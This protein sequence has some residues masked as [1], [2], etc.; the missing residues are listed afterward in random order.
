VGEGGQEPADAL[1]AR[2]ASA[3][4]IAAL[5]DPATAE[6][7]LAVLGDVASLTE[8]ERVERL[9]AVSSR[10]GPEGF[11]V[12]RL[13][14]HVLALFY[15]LADGEG[16]NPSWE[17][18]GYP[19][20]I[21]PPPTQE[22]APKTIPLT[23]PRGRDA[24]LE[25]DVCVVGSGGG[26]S[27]IAA[28]LQA[29]GRSVLVVEQGGYRN[30][31]DFRQL[32]LAGAGELY[33]GGGLV[34]SETGSLGLLAGATLGGGTVVNSL[35]CLRTPDG[36]R[37]DW[38]GRGLEGLDGPE[39]DAC[40]D[41][42]WARL[43]V[44][45]EGTIPNPSNRRMVEA[46]ERRGLSWELLPRNAAPHDPAFCGYCNAGCQQGE[47]NSTLQTY[48]QDAADAGA[49]FV[50]DCRVERVLSRGGRAAGVEAVVEHA[51]GERTALTVR[52]PVVVVAGG[53]LESPALLLR[54]GLGG[55]AVGRHLRVHPAWFVSGVYPDR[56]DAWSGQIQSVVSFDFAHLEHGAGFLCECVILS[57]TFWA[58][59]L[60][61]RDGA[62][63]KREMLKLAR[64]ASWHAV[65]HDHGAGR[66]TI[67]DAGRTRVHWALDD[68]RDRL[69]A[70]RAFAE[71][72]RLHHAAGAAEIT[73]FERPGLRWQAG[74]D[75]EGF[76]A[77]IE[78]VDDLVAYS[79]HQMGSCR[80]GADPQDSVA[81]GDGRLHDVEGVW[82]GDASA[83]PTAPG[84]NPMVTIMA[85]AERTA[86]RILGRSP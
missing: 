22:Q 1:L 62:E 24:V 27:V 67:D 73:T 36:V 78:T 70:R 42:V 40:L 43:G 38:A 46:L 53:G 54:S 23:A 71:L 2:P 35:V 15:G 37:A 75:F 49:R 13:R 44:N 74:D 81:D 30:E 25:A 76:L 57:P 34:W 86:A 3:L 19:G 39:F 55:R 72:S 8:P 47:K 77:G 6:E 83:L 66:V 52:A 65:S 14:A 33:L 9:R 17:A 85:L 11:A 69:S 20:P 21:S 59:S 32:E 12:R 61:W 63:H 16:R 41:A 68:E 79:A 29:A 60:P 48:L 45:T 7:A 31:A 10:P 58:A 18:I 5:V 82:V 26:G 84:V 28:R 64:V 51:D 4:G 56:L 80:M 50:V